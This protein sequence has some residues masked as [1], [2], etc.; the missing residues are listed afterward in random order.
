MRAIATTPSF[1]L[2]GEPL[3][4]IVTTRLGCRGGQGSGLAP[5][6]AAERAR[7]LVRVLSRVRRGPP[8]VRG[9]R[10]RPARDVPR[11]RRCAAPALPDLQCAVLVDVRGRL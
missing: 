11:L 8:L 6:G 10:S 9:L 1:K 2:V 7:T 5:R 3:K 4:A